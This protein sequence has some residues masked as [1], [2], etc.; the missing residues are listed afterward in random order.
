M[1][2][3]HTF[4]CSITQG[5]ALPDV[6]R[7]LTDSQGQALSEKQIAQSGIPWT[8]IHIYE[9]SSHA[10]PQLLGDRLGLDVENHARRGACFQQIARQCAVEAKNI[11]A[12]DTVIVMWT[13]MS[14][15]SLQWPARTSVPFANIVD[16]CGYGW[17]TVILGFNK[18]F[19]L[20][21]SPKATDDTDKRIQHYI[22]MSTQHT[23]LDP[24]GVYNRYYNSMVLQQITDGFLRATGARVIHLS[25]EPELL[26]DQL[27]AARQDLDPTL[28][29]PYVIP[30]PTD[31]YTI[32]VDHA[33][34]Q[35]IL[36]PSIP[37]A[38]NDMHP[39]LTHHKNFA[40]HLDRL[41][42]QSP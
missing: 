7:T 8:D 5:F 3:L 34:C 2:T 4:G 40:E 6:V 38:A 17:R 25:V 23:Y 14:R 39:S 20:T 24:M 36:D 35:V 31:W 42:F 10:W 29:D 13:Y 28:R 1:A 11:K 27:E 15:L 41:Y 19:G 30:N 18:F 21:P 33:S 26:L 32:P 9:P 22:E 12:E 37:P 16:P